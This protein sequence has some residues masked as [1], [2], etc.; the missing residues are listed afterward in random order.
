VEGIGMTEPT[1]ITRVSKS[2]YDAIEDLNRRHGYNMPFTKATDKLADIVKKDERGFINQFEWIPPSRKKKP[3]WFDNKKGSLFDVIIIGFIFFTIVIGG[4]VT[5]S[6][7]SDFFANPEL[8]RQI[9]T[10]TAGNATRT[11]ATTFNQGHGMDNMIVGAFFLLH[12]GM[13]VLAALTPISIV[14][15]VIDLILITVNVIIGIV[16]RELLT[17]TFLTLDAGKVH[18]P[19]TFWIA[20]NIVTIELVF[21]VLAII[22]MFM[23]ARSSPQ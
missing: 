2:L 20:Q 18:L 15:L 1:K 14:F 5:L 16:L 12:I 7:L 17:E 21:I 22:V 8:S 9:N 19:G 6:V 11:Q 10:T 23:A 4:V 13:L 3:L